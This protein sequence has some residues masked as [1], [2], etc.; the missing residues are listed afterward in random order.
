[1]DA[2]KT[3]VDGTKE[4]KQF[5]RN[6]RFILLSGIPVYFIIVGLLMQPLNP[7][8]HLTTKQSMRKSPNAVVKNVLLLQLQ[9]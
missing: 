1:M 6:H 4:M 9:E 2:A 3:I 8:N 5:A 7:Q